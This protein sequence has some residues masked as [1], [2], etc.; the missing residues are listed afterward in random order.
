MRVVPT[1]KIYSSRLSNM[2]SDWGVKPRFV[3]KP[4]IWL[5]FCVSLG[6]RRD[7]SDGPL[8]PRWSFRRRRASYMLKGRVNKEAGLYQL[9]GTAWCTTVE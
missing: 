6:R 1:L 2:A 9:V 8:S 3:R 5:C 7:L 4:I